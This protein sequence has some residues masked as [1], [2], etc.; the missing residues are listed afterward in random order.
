M[1][2][3]PV[4][5]SG[6]PPR[7]SASR[8]KVRRLR[9]QPWLGLLGIVVAIGIW[10]LVGVS[11]NEPIVLA[12]PSAVAVDLWQWISSGGIWSQLLVSAEEFAIGFAIAFAA[13]ITLGVLIGVSKIVAQTVYPVVQALNSTP[14]IALAPLIVIWF[15]FGLDSKIILIALIAFFPILANTDAGVRSLA[16]SYV[17]VGRSFGAG[18]LQMVFLFRL[19]ASV[20]FLL[21]GTRIAVARAIAGIFVGELY[22][23]TKGIGYTI[24]Q[25]G[26][27]F[28]TPRIFSAIAILA[29]FGV[30]ASAVVSWLIKKV[31]PWADEP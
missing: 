11:L 22:G 31:A 29:A 26:N 6:A 16:E 28:D 21:A 12:T 8:L 17:D 14:V 24:T 9:G 7:R 30:I 23:S 1:G 2:S 3:S 10:Q 18:P 5:G 19:P 4:D 15:G 13:G 27:T 25:A 20:P